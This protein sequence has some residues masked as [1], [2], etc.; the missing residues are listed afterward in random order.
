[1]PEWSPG[2]ALAAVEPALYGLL[3]HFGLPDE[4]AEQLAEAVEVLGHDK[5]Q[6]Q[7]QQQQHAARL[8]RARADYAQVR[9]EMT[10]TSTPVQTR[11]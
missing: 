8:A 10:C 2:T 5:Q 6:Q 1:M 3:D 4:L 11:R 7:Q 9:W